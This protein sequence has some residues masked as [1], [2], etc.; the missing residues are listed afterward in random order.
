MHNIDIFNQDYMSYGESYHFEYI[1][2][3]FLTCLMDGYYV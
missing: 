1:S 2:E 3:I